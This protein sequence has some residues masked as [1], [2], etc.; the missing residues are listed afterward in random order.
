[1]RVNPRRKELI[2]RMRPRPATSAA[3]YVIPAL[4]SSPLSNGFAAHVI[5]RPRTGH[6]RQPAALPCL[7]SPKRAKQRWGRRPQRPGYQSRSRA[8][9]GFPPAIS[10]SRKTAG[11]R[12]LCRDHSADSGTHV[13]RC[14]P[15]STR[16]LRSATKNLYSFVQKLWTSALPCGRPRKTQGELRYQLGGC[17]LPPD[18]CRVLCDRVGILTFR[19]SGAPVVLEP[20]ITPGSSLWILAGTETMV[21]APDLLH[22]STRIYL[23][24][25]ILLGVY[26][27]YGICIRNHR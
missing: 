2:K 19:R 27:D 18:P 23:D 17:R 12:W 16:L 9:L 24:T 13:F 5:S 26:K 8:P 20:Q 3:S 21:W 22:T 1:M 11:C 10:P 7:S 14:N 6:R 15:L 25:Y 4:P